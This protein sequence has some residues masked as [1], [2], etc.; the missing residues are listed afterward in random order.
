MAVTTYVFWPLPLLH[1]RKPYLLLSMSVALP[2]QFP[3]AAVVMSYRDPSAAVY[4]NVLLASRFLLGLSFGFAQIS[5]FPIL[6]DLFGASLQSKNPHEE[7]VDEDDMRRDGG[8]MGVWL[9]IW[10]WCS[11]GSVAVGFTCGAAIISSLNPQWGFY[12]CVALLIAVLF[13]NI[14]TPET[15]RSQFRRSSHRY[16]DDN[17][18]VQKTVGR[19]EV[20][21]H[22]SA[23]PPCCWP[24][25][26]WAGVKLS[27]GMLFQR[28]FAVV[29][30][31]LAWIYAEI[32]L[33]MVVRP[34][35]PHIS[36][37]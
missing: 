7:F 37:S 17:D 33:V 22:V 12:L 3:Q 14:V 18:Q 34:S 25:E 36:Q 24:E 23:E 26:V 20:K 10:T 9:G 6:L 4:R 8:G 29:A 30:V 21:L 5:L 16:F 19:G 15:R 2:L 11:L 27:A 28:G 31:Y 1:G 32:V 13:L 35:S